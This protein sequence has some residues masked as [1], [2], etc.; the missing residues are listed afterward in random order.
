MDLSN[1][2]IA[3]PLQ[4][5]RGG[6]GVTPVLAQEVHQLPRHLQVGDVAVQVDPIHGLHIQGDVLAQQFVD[7]AHGNPSYASHSI[8]QFKRQ[9][10]PRSTV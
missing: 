5:G 8:N 3:H 4:Q 7:S 1:E 6:D 10:T 2:P 9:P